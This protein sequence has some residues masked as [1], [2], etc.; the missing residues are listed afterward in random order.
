MNQIDQA[1]IEGKIEMIDY[2]LN[3]FCKSELSEG[4]RMN[5]KNIQFGL[6]KKIR[7]AEC[8]RSDK[9]QAGG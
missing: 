4:A 8:N 1:K 9:D 3:I 7:D 5:L 2:C 6:K